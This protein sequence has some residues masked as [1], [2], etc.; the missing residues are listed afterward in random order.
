[1]SDVERVLNR[2]ETPKRPEVEPANTDLVWSR[3][4]KESCDLERE[5]EREREREGESVCVRVC[6]CVLRKGQNGEGLKSHCKDFPCVL[7]GVDAVG[8]VGI[9]P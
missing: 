7:S 9:C 6:V 8:G 3:S 4:T 5:R 2:V 1:V